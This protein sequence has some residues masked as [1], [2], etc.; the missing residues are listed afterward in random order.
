MKQFAPS[1]L[2][3]MVISLSALA[4]VPN[5]WTALQAVAEREQA[6]MMGKLSGVVLDKDGKTPLP[7]AE[8][9]VDEW[10]L[11][12]GQKEVR[13]SITMKTGTDGRYLFTGLFTPGFVRVSVLINK[14][15][16]ITKGD[17]LG[18]EMGLPKDGTV[19]IVDFDLSRPNW[20]Y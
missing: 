10:L 9:Q 5:A 20:P 15:P 19:R 6:L 18:D 4:Q 16:M 8:V 11:R 7:N 14:Q 13:R 2:I 12:S 3:L 1:F 17:R